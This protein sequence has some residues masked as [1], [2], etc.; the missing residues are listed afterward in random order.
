MG[1]CCICVCLCICVY[2]ATKKDGEMSCVSN[3]AHFFSI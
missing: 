3:T 2:K 1:F